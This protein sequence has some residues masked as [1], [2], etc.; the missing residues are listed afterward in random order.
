[1]T[2]LVPSWKGWKWPGYAPGGPQ[3]DL[4]GSQPPMR[5]LLSHPIALG[6]L[7]GAPILVLVQVAELLTAGRSAAAARGPSGQ[8]G[9]AE[10]PSGGRGAHPI[11]RREFGGGQAFLVVATAQ[12]GGGRGRVAS[13][14]LRMRT[15]RDTCLLQPDANSST[16]PSHP[17]A[18]LGGGEPF[19]LVEPAQLRLRNAR[20]Q[21]HRLLPGCRHGS[22]RPSRSRHHARRPAPQGQ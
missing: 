22:G 6:D 8:A 2:V 4:S 16:A 9:I 1:M 12:V 17:H 3:G 5:G 20:W 21:L 19:L 7:C 13:W 18:D 15:Q 10:P 14:T 11:A